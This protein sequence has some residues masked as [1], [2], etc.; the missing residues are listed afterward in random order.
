[1]LKMILGLVFLTVAS[2]CDGG[3]VSRNKEELNVSDVSKSFNTQRTCIGR[4]VLD[5]PTDFTLTSAHP[6]IFGSEFSVLQAG[7]KADFDQLIERRRNQIRSLPSPAKRPNALFA[8][9]PHPRGHVF[10]FTSDDIAFEVGGGELEI[11]AHS[12]N[13]IFYSKRQ[14][15]QDRGKLQFLEEDFYLIERIEPRGAHEIPAG[16][17]FCFEGG[18][19]RS[20]RVDSELVTF[21]FGK[22]S[23]ES[24]NF[25]GT[26]D[27]SKSVQK[28]KDPYSNSPATVTVNDRSFLGLKGQEAYS[29]LSKA[30]DGEDGFFFIARAPV[31]S[32]QAG[33]PKVR[34]EYKQWARPKMQPYEPDE[35]KA[36]WDYILDTMRFTSGTW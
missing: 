27:T 10:G 15:V 17:A 12:Q 9:V 28:F 8:D 19:I 34:L 11:Y 1:M 32:I 5:T 26:V 18:F 7:S 33:S 35:I 31:K 24:T 6:T 36:R 22:H 29:F 23:L 14:A 20:E 16:P 30:V 4:L 3:L 21:N 2:N 25:K 13:T